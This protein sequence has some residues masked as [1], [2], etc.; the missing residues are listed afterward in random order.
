VIDEE[1][2]EELKIDNKYIMSPKDLC[3]IGFLDKLLDSGI[4]VLKLEGRG[5]SADYV[6]T[7][8]KAYRE[9][10]ESVIDGSYSKKKIDGWI[11]DLEGVYNR[12]FWHGGYYLGK[13]LGEWSGVYGSKSSKEKS[14]IGVCKH[15]YPKKE[16]G[17]FLL[18]SGKIE[19]GDE[20]IITGNSTGII[21]QKVESLYVD[22]KPANEAEKGDVVTMK[23]N[24]RVREND[25]LFILVDRGRYQNSKSKTVNGEELK[26]I[27][28]NG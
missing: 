8:T 27:D 24:E 11:K 10:V 9:G 21:K 7:V 13:K 15:Y 19:I 6:Y 12:G 22:E 20:I 18:T 28:N 5:R 2:G 23:V 4:C 1:T 17:E 16:I 14:L 26:V 3:T 25:R